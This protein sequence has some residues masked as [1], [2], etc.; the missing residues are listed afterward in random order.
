MSHGTLY[1]PTYRA[2]DGTLKRQAI[3][4]MQYFVNGRRVRESTGT[5]SRKEAERILAA[6][7]GRIVEGRPIPPRLDKIT[8]DEVAGDLR[9]HY[10]TTGCRDL[11]EGE[12]RHAANLGN[13]RPRG[14]HLGTNVQSRRGAREGAPDAA[15]SLPQ[16]SGAPGLI[17]RSAAV[18]GRPAPSPPGASRIIDLPP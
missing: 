18:R 4:W 13:R 9:R 2:P 6:R 16:G 5:R 17:C 14:L 11:A 3:W 15:D 10:R 7:I 1:R 12:K 8:Y